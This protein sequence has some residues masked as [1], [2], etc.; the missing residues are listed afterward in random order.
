MSLFSKNQIRLITSLIRMT[1]ARP[2]I[3]S[4][5]EL[6]FTGNQTGRQSRYLQNQTVQIAMK[7]TKSI[8]APQLNCRH[9]GKQIQYVTSAEQQFCS[10]TCRSRFNQSVRLQQYAGMTVSHLATARRSAKKSAQPEAAIP[11]PQPLT[12]LKPSAEV[13]AFAKDA[14]PEQLLALLE[15]TLVEL[16]EV[17]AQNAVFQEEIGKFR[18]VAGNLFYLAG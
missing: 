7:T 4:F 8:L 13:V 6:D 3:V 9:C 11:Q 18:R 5:N 2:T 14:T 16:A 10:N 15:K 1:I 12:A 17:K